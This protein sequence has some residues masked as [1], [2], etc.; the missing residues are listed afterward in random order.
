MELDKDLKRFLKKK[1]QSDNILK[2]QIRILE[3]FDCIVDDIKNI[4]EKRLLDRVADGDEFDCESVAIGVN[5]VDGTFFETSF[6][7]SFL[8]Y[9]Y[10]SWV[11]L[12]VDKHTLFK[13]LFCIGT[14]CKTFSLFPEVTGL[15]EKCDDGKAKSESEIRKINK[16]IFLKQAANNFVNP[17]PD[18]E[19]Q[20]DSDEENNYC[21]PF[22]SDDQVPPPTK[23]VN[24]FD[25]SDSESEEIFFES[26]DVCCQSFPTVAFVELH[27][28]IF[29]SGPVVKT[30]FVGS[31]ECLITSFVNSSPAPL[32]DSAAPSVDKDAGSLDTVHV[33]DKVSVCSRVT[34]GKYNFRKRLK[35]NS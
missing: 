35:Y 10:K 9:I 34:T 13:E 27:K 18:Y 29:H 4:Y 21:N 20:E 22:D 1:R 28:S 31:P 17:I 3:V 30:K 14:G 8:Y 26:C 23:Y 15:C 12:D 16:L 11:S 5:T 24:P 6:L 7:P 25:D 19:L 33:E 2:D 32:L